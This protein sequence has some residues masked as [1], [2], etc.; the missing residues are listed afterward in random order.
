MV[1]TEEKM[2]SYVRN[3]SLDLSN[4]GLANE[5]VPLIIK[6]VNDCKV[7]NL[8][9]MRNNF[10]SA[11]VIALVSQTKLLKLNLS[12]NSLSDDILEAIINKETIKDVNF[13]D[14]GVS[15]EGI[16]RFLESRKKI[17]SALKDENKSTNIAQNHNS[18]LVFASNYNGDKPVE[19]KNP[20]EELAQKII[21]VLQSDP[22]LY[23]K[24]KEQPECLK[25]IKRL[26]VQPESANMRNM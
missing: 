4:Y 21:K 6:V 14:S 11:D 1:L 8:N 25:T 22:E 9:L 3:S 10:R 26:L 2:K 7:T 15:E 17:E 12:F 16:K 5:A 13:D 23:N 18:P 19:K 24:L 20:D